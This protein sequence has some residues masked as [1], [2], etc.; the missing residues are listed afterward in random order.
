MS[1]KKVRELGRLATRLWN[2]ALDS[3][4]RRNFSSAGFCSNH[5]AQAGDFGWISDV[6]GILH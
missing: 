6:R 4:M 3:L 2:A 1:S 5:H